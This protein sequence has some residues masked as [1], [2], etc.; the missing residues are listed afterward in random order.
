MAKF[1][2][3]KP[4]GNKT[5]EFVIFDLDMGLP[6]DPVLVVRPAG[7]VNRDYRNAVLKSLPQGRRRTKLPSN[8][9]ADQMMHD[10]DMELYPKH[11]VVGWRNVREDDGT[12]PEF[13]EGNVRDLLTALDGVGVFAE[14]RNFCSDVGNFMD[15]PDAE[16]TAGNSPP[17]SNGS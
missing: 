7:D 16:D 11:V 9:K 2:N 15:L 3:I 8:D 1:G 17:V 12:E 10:I 5:A 14:L 6:E 4:I 13:N